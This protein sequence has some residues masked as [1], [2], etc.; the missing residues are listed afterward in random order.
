MA[1]PHYTMSLRQ[2]P[3]KTFELARTRDFVVLAKYWTPCVQN[4]DSWLQLTHMTDQCIMVHCI[5]VLSNLFTRCRL[6]I[7]IKYHSS[8]DGPNPKSGPKLVPKWPTG[9]QGIKGWAYG[10]LGGQRELLMIFRAVKVI[11]LLAAPDG[12]AV[13]K[14]VQEVLADLKI[15]DLS[16][17]L[18][19]LT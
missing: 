2:I 16:T 15:D 10:I 17:Y 12:E 1:E 14:A 11:W 9:S 19:Y 3:E 5:L 4:G 7:V 13:L 8:C 18:V 6:E